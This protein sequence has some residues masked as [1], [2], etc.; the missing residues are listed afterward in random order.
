MVL[1]RAEDEALANELMEKMLALCARSEQPT[2][3]QEW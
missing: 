3:G 2:T 1:W